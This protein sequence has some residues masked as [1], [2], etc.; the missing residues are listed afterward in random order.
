MGPLG[1]ALRCN[2]YSAQ[3]KISFFF[4][5]SKGGSEFPLL[6]LLL[7]VEKCNSIL[8]QTLQ[9]LLQRVKKDGAAW[10]AFFKQVKIRRASTIYIQ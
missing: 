2:C 7:G 8:S 10:F 1:V 9:Y 5:E 4:L 3:K 6:D